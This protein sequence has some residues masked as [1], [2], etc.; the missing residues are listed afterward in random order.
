MKEDLVTHEVAANMLGI[1]TRQLQ[2]MVKQGIIK[3]HPSSPSTLKKRLFRVSDLSAIQEIR[4][5]GSNPEAAFVEA[6]QA[7]IEV[8]MLRKE[9]ER[10]RVV[11][12]LNM[13]IINTDRDTVMR[14][15]I[16]A[17]DELREIPSQDHSK[18]LYWARVFHA[19]TEAHLEA[20]TFHS[21]QK[22]PWKSFLN[23]GRH[24]LTG[25]NSMVTRYDI[26]LNNIYLLVAAGLK[27]VRQV[28]YFHVRNLYGKEYA[29][30]LMPEVKGCPHEDVIA[31]SL[32]GTSWDPKS[33]H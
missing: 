7:A 28:A 19:I 21:S 15:L 8:R 12:G 16:E 31:M 13:P 32:N 6:R 33:L 11:L 22:E 1:T 18:L 30:K 4:A 14:L 20:I 17:E 24:L 9:V 3:P 26:E 27:S 23:L 2:R 25:Y 10:M 29:A 5:Q